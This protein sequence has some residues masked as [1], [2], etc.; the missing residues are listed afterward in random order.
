MTKTTSRHL[1]DILAQVPDPR[2]AK[3]KR[4]PLGAILGLAVIAMMCGYRSY[5]A[6]AEWG[7]TY[8]SAWVQALGFTHAKTPC[9]ATLHNL[10]KR[11]DI[12]TLE[13]VL[14]QWVVQTLQLHP[15][16]SSQ[17]AVAIDG[18]MLNGSAKQQATVS[19]LLS[20][21]SHQLGSNHCPTTG[22]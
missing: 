9:A 19:H 13:S 15:V 3:G 2:N 12:A 21:V 6:I 8:A 7:R 11:L 5:S 16:G 4:H 14:S 17:L 18:K 1:I 20:V 22:G 10:F